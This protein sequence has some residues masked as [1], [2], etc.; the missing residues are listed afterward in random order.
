MAKRKPIPPYLT[1]PKDAIHADPVEGWEL[2]VDDNQDRIVGDKDLFPSWD[3][4]LNFI[5]RRRFICD[6]QVFDD[7]LE[8]PSGRASYQ[9]V[10]R[11]ETAGGLVSQVVFKKELAPDDSTFE[12]L[13]APDS[14]WLSKDIVVSCSLVVAS[15][16]GHLGALSPSH[17]GSRVW[18]QTWSAKLEGGRTRLPIEIISFRTQLHDLAIPNALLHVSV[19]D[20][21]QLEFEQAVCVYLNSDHP[22]F[23]ADFERGEKSATAM[24][25]DS[26]VRQVLSAALSEALDDEGQATPE[27]TFGA[28]LAVWI[29]SIFPGESRRT[30]HAMRK[31]SSGLF[32][33][34]IQSWVNAAAFWSEGESR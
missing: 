22:R 34:R 15:V 10:V 4:S 13:I 11:L 26:V 18:S 14:R 28:Q 3:S 7:H 17:P 9:F 1:L 31:D 25:W 32:E 8:I 21:P 12:V 30:L 23:V 5:L 16:Q 20:D 33:S 2:L 19:A 6:P 27:G 24:V 29:E